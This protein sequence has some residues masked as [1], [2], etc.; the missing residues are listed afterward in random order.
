[1]LYKLTAH[2]L[3]NTV[4]VSNVGGEG[5]AKAQMLGTNVVLAINFWQYPH[6]ALSFHCAQLFGDA[7]VCVYTLA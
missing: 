6:L 2:S 1:M 4:S 5:K 7:C 3:I